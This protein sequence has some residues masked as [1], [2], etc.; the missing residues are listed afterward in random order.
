MSNKLGALSVGLTV[1]MLAGAA[2]VSL[3]TSPAQAVVYCKTVGVPKGCVVRPP[4]AVVVAP[5]AAAAVATP[6]IGAPGVGVRAGTPMNRGGPV[7]RVGV[8]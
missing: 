8:R 5:V 7:N 4:A 1:M 2:T 3:G 6:G